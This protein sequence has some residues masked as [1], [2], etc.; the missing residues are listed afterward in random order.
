[1]LDEDHYLVPLQHAGNSV[2]MSHSFLALSRD[3]AED[4]FVEAKNRLWNVNKWAAM[5]SI[6]GISFQLSDAAGKPV[7]S[8][9][10]PH[11][12]IQ[13]SDASGTTDSMV[14]DAI[15]YDDYP[16]DDTETFALRLHDVH[17]E[18]T[19][20][21]VLVILRYGNIVTASYYGRNNP[22][23]H[24]SAWH[25]LHHHQWEQLLRSLVAM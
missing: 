4:I 8:L 7:R 24:S 14:I 2:N 18:G 23:M 21:T 6:P 22:G 3:E 10:H 9:A 1:M 15:E 11:H 17:I 12:H 16:D 25:G 20:S 19:A 5:A 13:V